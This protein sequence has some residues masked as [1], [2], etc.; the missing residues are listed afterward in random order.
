MK[1]PGR[2]P[3]FM[4]PEKWNVYRVRLFTLVLAAAACTG[5]LR[6]YA[7][8]AGR[9]TSAIS[10]DSSKT[11]DLLLERARGLDASSQRKTAAQTWQ[12]VLLADPQNAEA[13]AGL[14]K[15]FRNT[16][17][18]S[19]SQ[20]YLSRLRKFHPTDG[21]IAAIL[22]LSPEAPVKQRLEEA[23]R[24]ATAGHTADAMAIYRNIYGNHPPAGDAALTYYE[25]EAGLP[26]GRADAVAG[27]RADALRYPADTRYAI[28]LGKI[29]TENPD[30]RAEGIEMLEP[31]AVSHTSAAQALQEALRWESA[32]PAHLPELRKY[33]HAHPNAELQQEM[34]QTQT[35][36]HAA[37]LQDN[38]LR[39]DAVA[40]LA[41]TPAQDQ[42]FRA[43]HDGHDADAE[44]YFQAILAAAPKDGPALAGMGLVRLRQQKFSEARQYL[45]RAIQNGVTAV[46]VQEPLDTVR[47]WEQMQN[48]NAA[49]KN[50]DV[51]AAQIA[52]K[53]ALNVRPDSTGAREGLAAAQLALG[54][55]SAAL[56]TLGEFPLK[57]QSQLAE[58]IRFVQL[59]SR[60]Y[61]ASGEMEKALMVLRRFLENPSAKLTAQ[62][63]E[64]IGLQYA[65][66]L[67]EAK[68]H[69]QAQ[70]SYRRILSTDPMNVAAWKGIVQCMHESGD[71]D[72]AWNALS[73][74]PR[75]SYQALLQDAGVLETLSSVA[76][77]QRH[78]EQAEE[79]L[80]RAV[81]QG[82]NAGSSSLRGMELQSASQYMQRKQPRKAEAMYRKIVA[83]DSSALRRGSQAGP[84]ELAAWKGR[85]LALHMAD[86]NR[87]AV[88][89]EQAL[90]RAVSGQLNN[91]PEY[92]ETMS[93][94]YDELGSTQAAI[95]R[96]QQAETILIADGRKPS[97][98]MQIQ[99]CW[100]LYRAHQGLLLLPRLFP[101][102]EGQ[103]LTA[104][105]KRDVSQIW[106]LWSLR[107]TDRYRSEGRYGD[108]VALEEKAFAVFPHNARLRATLAGA[109]IEA[110][111]PTKTV[112]MYA[113]ADVRLSTPEDVRAAIGAAMAAADN[114]KAALWLRQ[115][116]AQYPRNP[117]LLVLYAIWDQQQEQDARAIENLRS[118][119]ALMSADYQ[120][121]RLPSA[122]A[123]GKTTGKSSNSQPEASSLPPEDRVSSSVALRAL[124][125]ALAAS[126][127]DSA[128]ASEGLTSSVVALPEPVPLHRQAADLL[129][130]MDS[131]LS[132]W[133]GGT[134]YL[135]HRS[136]TQGLEQLTDV[137][138]P[139]DGSAVFANRTRVTVVARPVY[140]Y[141]GAQLPGDPLPVGTLSLGS[142]S[143][144]QTSTGVASEVQ[145]ATRLLDA[146]I[147]I[148][149][150]GF[151]VAPVVGSA[152]LRVPNTK[153][154]LTF[155]RDN[156]R[157]SELSYAGL[158][159]PDRT[160]STYAGKIWGGVVSNLGG[161]QYTHGNAR[162]G[163]FFTGSAG[164]LTGT[165]VET[166][167]TAQVDTGAYWRLLKKPET[168]HLV[169][170]ANFFGMHYA[171]DDLYFTY[172][173]GG[174]FSPEYFLL[175]NLPVT[176]TGHR[177]RNFH[178]DV[179]GTLGVQSFRQASAK[180]FPLDTAL[181]VANGNPVYPSRTTT[182]VNYGAQAD[183][184]W[185]LAGHWYAG[186]F[187]NVNNAQNYNQQVA[188][189]SIHYALRRQHPR[190]E[191]PTG[192]FPYTG[193]NS[194]RIP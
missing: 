78:P 178:Y 98:D 90:P 23:G 86:D 73:T 64:D 162:K 13:L 32:D 179:E 44:K 6:G 130:E 101:L 116:R 87:G 46:L 176:W 145:I 92:L 29:L 114:R 24:L 149:P 89:E 141:D 112:K 61:A 3:W 122:D 28:A 15:Y 49:L 105:Q 17:A 83:G 156:V 30:T 66:L 185:L 57:L 115:A 76:L 123:A 47:F 151:R 41:Q 103:D 43:L 1:N 173:Q 166:N 139:V 50:H 172:G 80:Q 153:L 119:L 20:V 25:T 175:G 125:D 127:K 58:S 37:S 84:D 38:H 2:T 129:A 167:K 67:T 187:V 19:E 96:L 106:I 169:L 154:T 189:I 158:K 150:V 31:L 144:A 191:Q 8:Q 171:H 148:S 131:R 137:E 140:L 110:H 174:Y 70:E 113:N 39:P 69:E 5:S 121:D 59:E 152:A 95:V 22:H 55:A 14:A 26:G 42:G 36:F 188:G 74:M 143:A 72:A 65:A 194:L 99:L 45:E 181:Q 97:N 34:E 71:D 79:Y 157:D 111:E 159:N 52:Y 10:N 108:A 77:S 146:S 120:V 126:E 135:N 11:V 62:Q 193:R 102:S 138:I 88:A 18:I 48:A 68:H 53:A 142:T 132:S 100:L 60:A 163:I 164:V 82:A 147:G 81:E 27:L 170:A 93:Q 124:G 21:R 7:I 9:A 40:G 192:V 155:V 134:P 190:E 165:H 104:Q 94:V 182:G 56:L 177:G 160:S 12:Q 51:E 161:A 54:N 16:G 133:V 85:F 128:N 33:L 180:Y 118:A 168:G 109:Y 136:G 4:V 35:K 107:R 183:G 184:A 91:D 75:A 186:G 63:K 117:A